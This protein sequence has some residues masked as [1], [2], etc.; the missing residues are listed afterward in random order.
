MPSNLLI[1]IEYMEPILEHYVNWFS[2]PAEFQDLAYLK[3]QVG[4]G[5][6]V[7][8]YGYMEI[9]NGLLRFHDNEAYEP[10]DLRRPSFYQPLIDQGVPFNFWIKTPDEA[11][12]M[13]WYRPDFV[14][15]EPKKV[16]ANEERAVLTI[17]Q[18]REIMEQS[19]NAEEVFA[20]LVHEMQDRDPYSL[21][22]D[23][24]QYRNL[25][26]E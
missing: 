9:R 13:I 26:K 20:A 8:D 17:Y 24:Q 23:I 3:Y 21:R 25:I 22:W 7:N 1:P 19:D 4:E 16:L 6:E 11:E 15:H 18:I 2:L 14:I 10:Y 12:N 5:Y